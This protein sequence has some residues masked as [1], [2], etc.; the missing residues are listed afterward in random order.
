MGYFASGAQR[1]RRRFGVAGAVL[2]LAALVGLGAPATAAAP[3]AAPAA[4][5]ATPDP[6]TWPSGAG[7]RSA[8]DFG[9]WRNRPVAVWDTWNDAKTWN[10]MRQLWTLGYYEG[11]PRF[12]GRM[13]FAQPLLDQTSTFADCNRGTYDQHYRAIATGLVGRGFGNAIIRL[14]WE[15]N[16]DW[17]AWKVGTDYAGFQNCF[18]R[19]SRIFKAASPAYAIEWSAAASWTS[20]RADLAYPGDAVVDIIG[21]DFYDGWPAAPTASAFDA[22]CMQMNG[23]SPVGLCRFAE[24]ARAHRKPFSVP[25]WG[26]RNQAGDGGG[27]DNAVFVAKMFEFFQRNADILAYEAY[28]DLEGGTFE[29][30]HGQNPRAAAA[31]RQRWARPA[32]AAPTTTTPRPTTTTRPP[33]TTTRPPTT[34]PPPAARLVSWTS[35]AEVGNPAAFGTWRGRPVAVTNVANVGSTWRDMM[36]V[37]ALAPYQNPRFPGRLSFSQPLLDSSSTLSRC[38]VGG[39]DPYFRRIGQELVTRGFADAFVRLGPGL[40][41]TDYANY[42]ACFTRAARA[43]ESASSAFRIEWSPAVVLARPDLAYPGDAVVDVVGTEVFDAS[44]P[45]TT[46]AAFDSRCV[47]GTAAA[48]IGLC[49][50]AEFA[51]VHRKPLSVPGWGVRSDNPVFVQRMFDVLDANRAI[52]AYE[53]YGEA[54]PAS[55]LSTGV[56]PNA[57]AA[58]RARWRA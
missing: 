53:S 34:T 57:A 13:A 29:I 3:S 54:R 45:A 28:F 33:T 20:T 12:P 50:W 17:Y 51:K 4:A 43:F 40:A 19:A 30:S 37:R 47:R 27:G 38:A 52:L 22:K 18:A 46:A 35:G 11:P 14:G 9:A 32:A 36:A 6:V 1:R 41:T 44:P 10:D 49:R 55:T 31:Y 58:Y 2:A 21:A 7:T 24:F 5:A 48:P 15:M 23:T 16:G 25:E 8:T 56:R 39:Y 42:K 26:I